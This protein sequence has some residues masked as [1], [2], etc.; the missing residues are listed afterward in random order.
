MEDWKELVFFCKNRLQLMYT[1]IVSCAYN[2]KT[3]TFYSVICAVSFFIPAMCIVYVCSVRTSSKSK[4]LENAS[5][6]VS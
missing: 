1:I 2:L 4:S 5:Y 6:I 3:H